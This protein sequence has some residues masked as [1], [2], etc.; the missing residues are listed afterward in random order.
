MKNLTYFIK[1]TPVFEMEKDGEA[2]MLLP[3]KIVYGYFTEEDLV[4]Y[5]TLEYVAESFIL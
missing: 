3:P 4:V 1:S 5:V 2:T